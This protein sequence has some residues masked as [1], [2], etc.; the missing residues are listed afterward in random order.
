MLLILLSNNRIWSKSL[1]QHPAI[2]LSMLSGLWYQL[3]QNQCYP[4]C[5]LFFQLL[6]RS[7]VQLWAKLS[8]RDLDYPI[9]KTNNGWHSIDV[10]FHDGVT[11]ISCTVLA[12]KAASTLYMNHCHTV[13]LRLPKMQDQKL[14]RLH[15]HSI[16]GWGRECAMVVFAPNGG[17]C[18]IDGCLQPIAT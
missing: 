18:L 13:T 11:K 4:F 3:F 10:H 1:I 16:S 8:A 17:Q 5:D 14:L 7:I 6:R 2:T 12:E 9:Y 15:W